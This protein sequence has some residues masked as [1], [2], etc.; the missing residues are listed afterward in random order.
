MTL[1]E[2]RSS[3]DAIAA[4]YDR[5]WSETD[6]GLWQRKAVWDAI[7]PLFARGDRVLDIGCGTGV[8]AALLMAR[9]ISVVAVDA[10]AEMV[11]VAQSKAVPAQ[12]L[13]AEQLDQ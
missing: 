1:T 12:H 6:S 11:R 9:G 7:Q 8:D 2:T 3:F 5:L 10:S 4:D 13:A